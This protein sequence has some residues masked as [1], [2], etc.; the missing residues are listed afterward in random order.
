L[1]EPAKA[2]EMGLRGQ[3]LVQEEFNWGRMEE[4]L[5][6]FYKEVLSKS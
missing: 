5:L 3:R 6:A 2:I 1:S 4:R